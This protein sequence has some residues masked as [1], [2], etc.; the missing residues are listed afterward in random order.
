MRRAES[1]VENCIVES[2]SFLYKRKEGKKEKTERFA[3]SIKACL[4]HLEARSRSYAVCVLKDR[5]VAVFKR[6][7]LPL[8]AQLF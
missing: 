2:S 1:E 4:I 6:T 3:K 5:T 7:L 8:L